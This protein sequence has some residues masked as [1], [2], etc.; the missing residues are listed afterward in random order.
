MAN[1]HGLSMPFLLRDVVADGGPP[2]CGVSVRLGGGVQ[3]GA[4]MQITGRQCPVHLASLSSVGAGRP[5][6]WRFVSKQCGSVLKEPSGIR[7]HSSPIRSQSWD[8]DACAL[9]CGSADSVQ[10]ASKAPA[11]KLSIAFTRL[12]FFDP[13]CTSKNLSTTGFSVG[14]PWAGTPPFFA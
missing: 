11:R 3:D 12:A 4:G 2:L 14:R 6:D 7:G 13:S 9:V 10:T 1:H 8:Q 5:V